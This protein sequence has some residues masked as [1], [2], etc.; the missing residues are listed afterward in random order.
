M[1][2]KLSSLP[3]L[4]VFQA[5]ALSSPLFTHIIPWASVAA[6]VGTAVILL[7][8]AGVVLQRREY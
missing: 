7:L 1:V 3:F 6:S 4:N 8:V 5:M 2:P